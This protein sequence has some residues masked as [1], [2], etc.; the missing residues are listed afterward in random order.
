MQCIEGNETCDKLHIF[1]II[2]C[3]KQTSYMKLEVSLHL[4]LNNPNVVN[5][6]GAIK[7]KPFNEKKMIIQFC[8]ESFG[9]AMT[10]WPCVLLVPLTNNSRPGQCGLVFSYGPKLNMSEPRQALALPREMLFHLLMNVP[11]GVPQGAPLHPSLGGVLPL[12]SC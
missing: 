4:T 8:T 7:P 5:L 9:Q 11:E 3:L 10:R 2:A 12:P 1:S 6:K